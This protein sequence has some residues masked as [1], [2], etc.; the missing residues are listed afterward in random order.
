MTVTDGTTGAWHVAVDRGPSF[1]TDVVDNGGLL[2]ASTPTGAVAAAEWPT[3]TVASGPR[4]LLC[5][6]SR[7]ADGAAIE[8]RDAS[9]TIHVGA[10]RL[11]SG[12]AGSGA[13]R[14]VVSYD[15]NFFELD[16]DCSPL[17]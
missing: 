9:S 11:E 14:C 1:A 2:L 3:D 6:G 5:M 12:R 17:P 7:E 8:A 10:S 13:F 16:K 15:G 4:L